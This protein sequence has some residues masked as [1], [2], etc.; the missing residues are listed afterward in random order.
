[1]SLWIIVLSVGISGCLLF[2]NNK[3]SCSADWPWTPYITV[4]NSWSFHSTS[5]ILGLWA[6]AACLAFSVIL[7][8]NN[9]YGTNLI[10]NSLLQ[11]WYFF[12]NPSSPASVPPLLS[13]SLCSFLFLC[14]QRRLTSCLPL[15]PLL[16]VGPS[17]SFSPW[18]HV[19]YYSKEQNM[20]RRKV[21]KRGL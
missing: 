7:V 16:R 4:F 17:C 1:M 15:C 10:Q 5:Q 13:F 21:K 18:S 2:A 20:R 11:N 14:H 6:P 8:C 3:I 9:E 12:F 19:A